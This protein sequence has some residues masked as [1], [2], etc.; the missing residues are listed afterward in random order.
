[1]EELDARIATKALKV[2]SERVNTIR[3]AIV[4]HKKRND[5]DAFMFTYEE[6]ADPEIFFVPYVWEVIV[7]CATA[8]SIEWVK[9]DIRVF[10]LLDDPASDASI[11]A[12]ADDLDASG[13][14][15]A[16]EFSKDLADV[17]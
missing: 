13:L 8:S 10:P 2:L 6:E 7:C 12:L 15:P 17:A 5:A 3:D 11:A 14:R 9:P 4:E 16:G 1:M